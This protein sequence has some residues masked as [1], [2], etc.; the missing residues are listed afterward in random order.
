[1]FNEADIEN[2]MVF[3]QSRDMKKRAEMYEEDEDAFR[4]MNDYEEDLM[5]KF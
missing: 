1:M 2:Q 4:E 3:K 5:R